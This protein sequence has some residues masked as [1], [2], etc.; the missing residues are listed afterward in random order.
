VGDLV[1][2]LVSAVGSGAEP[3]DPGSSGGP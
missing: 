1:L 3:P 2:R